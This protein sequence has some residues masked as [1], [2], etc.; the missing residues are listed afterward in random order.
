MCQAC[1]TKAVKAAIKDGIWCK[2]CIHNATFNPPKMFFS[3]KPP[4]CDHLA[5]PTPSP[6]ISRESTPELDSDVGDVPEPE[7]TEYLNEDTFDTSSVTSSPEP[8]I[9]PIN[10]LMRIEFERPPRNAN[11]MVQNGEFYVN[12]NNIKRHMSIESNWRWLSIFNKHNNICS[13]VCQHVYQQIANLEQDTRGSVT[14]E[15]RV[16]GDMI[17]WNF[18]TTVYDIHGQGERTKAIESIIEW[19]LVESGK[20]FLNTEADLGARMGPTWGYTFS[21]LL[22][23][24]GVKQ[25]GWSVNSLNIIDGF[26]FGNN[27]AQQHLS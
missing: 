27:R 2:G 4:T 5:S 14:R 17:M 22:H 26:A 25:H 24:E 8:P 21:I 16:W 11:D 18:D 19:I 9:S 7:I 15:K 6:E 12:S 3:H 1:Y 13:E 10:P 23:E 20:D